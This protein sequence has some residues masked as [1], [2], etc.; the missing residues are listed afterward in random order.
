MD[1]FRIMS[2]NGIQMKAT[3]LTAK[4][5]LVSLVSLLIIALT[6][7]L[8][9]AQTTEKSDSGSAAGKAKNAG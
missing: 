3:H 4:H 9:L 6:A 2:K 8:S 5:V 1:S 7:Y